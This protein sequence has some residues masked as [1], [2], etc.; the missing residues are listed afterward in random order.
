MGGRKLAWTGFWY[1]YAVGGIVFLI[2]IGY[3]VRQGE[4]GL[5]RGQPRRNLFMLVGGM[6]LAFGLH[7]A[8]MLAG[9]A[10]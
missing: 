1:Q 8:M 7:L 4:V 10:G 2:G 6:A 9:S 3:T 5:R